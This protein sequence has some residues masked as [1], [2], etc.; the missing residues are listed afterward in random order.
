MVEG[1]MTTGDLINIHPTELKFPCK[2]FE[3]ENG[4]QL[5]GLH[6]DCWWCSVELKK[7]SS[8]SM[9]L[10]N[11]T[12]KFVAFKVE[13]I[14]KSCVWLSFDGCFGNDLFDK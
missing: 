12:S 5:N 10:T 6:L 4:I 14:I 11:K 7:Q 3:L 1:V 9:Q 8:C 13:R 2:F